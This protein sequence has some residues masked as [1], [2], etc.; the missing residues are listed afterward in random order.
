MEGH[1]SVDQDEVSLCQAFFPR[2]NA[3]KTKEERYKPC[4][5]ILFSYFVFFLVEHH[6]GWL[7]GLR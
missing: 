7:T 2:K 4:E 3:L 5:R 1:S 6:K